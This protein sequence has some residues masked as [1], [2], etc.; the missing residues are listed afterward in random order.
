MSVI[1]ESIKKIS[2]AN[3]EE[4]PSQSF[5]TETSAAALKAIDARPKSSSGR[6]WLLPLMVFT[7]ML[8]AASLIY[9]FEHDA[10]AQAEAKLSNA[11]NELSDLRAQVS[12]ISKQKAD[13]EKDL[14]EQIETLQTHLKNA[15]DEKESLIHEKQALEFDNLSKEKRN[16]QLL[17]QA[18]R[19]QMDK[20]HLAGVVKDLRRKISVLPEPVPYTHK[21]DVS[22]VSSSNPVS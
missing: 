21:S 11:L 20:L 2:Q 13:M 3:K 14:N 7:V 12:E 22:D 4:A 17:A 1:H 5:D 19:V 8:V 15:N 6:P 16:S 10:R 18:H 9:A